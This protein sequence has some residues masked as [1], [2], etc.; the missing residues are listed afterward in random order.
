MKTGVMLGEV[1][2]E[3]LRM[4]MLKKLKL[5]AFCVGTSLLEDT[6][7]RRKRDKGGEK[8]DAKRPYRRK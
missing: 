8:G 2:E 6:E 1:A 3:H 7:S 5:A 4:G